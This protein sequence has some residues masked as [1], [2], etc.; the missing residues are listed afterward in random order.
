MSFSPTNISLIIQYALLVAGEEDSLFDRQLGPIHLIKYVYLAD[1]FYA[2]RNNGE[3][4]T[5]VDWRFYNFGPWSRDV[6]KA[7]DPA[8]QA[9]NAD[10]II[11]ESDYGDKGEWVRWS[12]RDDHLLE[13]K[14]RELPA[15]ITLHLRREVHKYGKDTP[16]LLDYVYKT[17]PMLYAAP[18]ER[19]DFSLV[20]EDSSNIRGEP[21]SLR[22]EN[23][24]NKKKKKFS[25][26]LRALQKN[27]ENK[28]LIQNSLVNPIKNPRY[29]E[30]YEDG[31]AW[32]D[33]L[34]GPQLGIGKKTA[35][36]SEDVWKS[37]TRKGE[38]V[39]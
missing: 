15:A 6:F 25:E 1:L 13:S 23:L 30:I 31:V 38:D 35:Q 4:F 2:K 12:L 33:K 39:S 5:G 29:D 14:S 11:R 16:S 9:I 34:A 22:M 26:G 7:I 28:E 27:Q 24:S 19:L 32:L 10:K 37:M 36:F 20:V 8:L 3:I 17:K 18:D 21:Q